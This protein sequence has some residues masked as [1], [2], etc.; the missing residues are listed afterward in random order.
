[1]NK[2][3]LRKLFLEKRKALPHKNSKAFN[4]KIK[5]HFNDFLQPDVNTLHIF[6]PIKSFQ[7]INTW[8]IIHGLW[9]KNIRVV[10]PVMNL[11]TNTIS[12]YQ[13][14]K[15][16]QLSENEWKVPEPMN[17]T[18]INENTID[19]IVMPLLAFDKN[20]YRVGYGR[21]YYDKFLSTLDSSPLK[22]G[23]SFFPPINKIMDLN[24]HDI[25]LDYC[26]TPE[27]IYKF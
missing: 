3:E 10:A 22:I 20:G 21:G 25:P 16:T 18:Q 14:T 12:S 27:R 1:M 26:I 17:S 13:L 9:A 24:S 7:E 6:M 5:V 15:E 19:V 8:P 2:Y 23:L 4:Y 11:Q